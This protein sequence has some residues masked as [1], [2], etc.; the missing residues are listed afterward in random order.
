MK[1]SLSRESKPARSHFRGS[2]TEKVE[3]ALASRMFLTSPILCAQQ[4]STPS[5]MNPQ[6][7]QLLLQRMD[8]LE[9]R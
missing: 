8:Q 3:I 6:T 2:D 7:T 9:Q 4:S 5:D 1:Y